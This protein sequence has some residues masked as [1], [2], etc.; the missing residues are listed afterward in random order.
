MLFL[1]LFCQV[2]SDAISNE[3]EQGRVLTLIVLRQY[4]LTFLLRCRKVTQITIH[5]GH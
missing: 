2:Y 3:L 4:I 1:E 5:L